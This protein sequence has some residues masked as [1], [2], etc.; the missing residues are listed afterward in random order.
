MRTHIDIDGKLMRQSMK[1]TGE[2]TKQAAIETALRKLV[3]LDI[4]DQAV[5]EVFR[6]QEIAR[7]Q[8]EREGRLDEWHAELKRK[9]NYPPW[10]SDAD[11]PQ[12][13]DELLQHAMKARES[14]TGKAVVEE[15]L[16]LAVQLDRQTRVLRKLRGIGW[17]GNL[18][19]MRTTRFPDWDSQAAEETHSE[20][21]VRQRSIA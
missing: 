3:A 8:A 14:S 1:A 13:Y 15:A 7:K 2:K 17:E 21:P 4:H 12:G 5:A 16:R 9:G 10:P 20:A 18:D 11:L 6:L 19:E